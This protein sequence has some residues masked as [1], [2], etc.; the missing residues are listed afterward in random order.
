MQETDP[1]RMVMSPVFAHCLETF[2]YIR[3][4]ERNM[5]LYSCS[6][7]SPI[8]NG[9]FEKA[10]VQR[11]MRFSQNSLSQ[12]L[13]NSVIYFCFDSRFIYYMEAGPKLNEAKLHG[14]ARSALGNIQ[15]TYSYIRI[16]IQDISSRTV[17]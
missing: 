10:Q 11:D 1:D 2:L 14:S 5:A 4:I 8:D 7:A 16:F 12:S 13:D 15:Y 9:Q 6:N 17:V 3:S